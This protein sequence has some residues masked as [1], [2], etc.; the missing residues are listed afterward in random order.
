M[1][2]LKPAGMQTVPTLS[3]PPSLP[4][5]L[6]SFL[7]YIHALQAPPARWWEIQG[8]PAP[9]PD[10]GAGPSLPVSCEAGNVSRE[11]E[12]GREGKVSTL[13][14]AEPFIPPSI[15]P[16]LDHVTYQYPFQPRQDPPFS[17]RVAH[18]KK[19]ARPPNRHKRQL[20]RRHPP[21][22]SSSPPSIPPSVQR[23]VASASYS[24]GGAPSTPHTQSSMPPMRVCYWT[25][26]CTTSTLHS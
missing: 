14:T 21:T 4:P 23:V 10:S 1:I 5:S 26:T 18:E 15:P 7:T 24:K 6:P 3:V 25:C 19:H 13:G 8:S 11:R 22:A 20:Q 16:F 17:Q 2:F 12:G 9:G